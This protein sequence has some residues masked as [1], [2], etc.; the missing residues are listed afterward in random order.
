MTGCKRL[1]S[2]AF[3]QI[4]PRRHSPISVRSGTPPLRHFSF[5][6]FAPGPEKRL[7]RGPWRRSRQGGG[8]SPTQKRRPQARGAAHVQGF[9]STALITPLS[10]AGRVDR[11]RR[12]QQGWFEWQIAEGN[13]RA[14]FPVRDDGREG[15]TLS[16]EEHK[17]VIEL[18]IKTAK[19]KSGVPGDR[20][21]PAP[22]SHGRGHRFHPFTPRRWARNAVLHST[23]LLQTNRPKTA[24]YRHFQGPISEAVD[25][26]DLCL[27]TCR[28]A[29][30]STSRVRDHLA[31][32][33][34]GS[35]IVIGVKDATANCRAGHATSA[36]PAV[37]TSSRCRVRTVLF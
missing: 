8:A 33:A 4:P 35:S 1:R 23:G 27:Q 6:C 3:A 26:S 24:L 22:N 36:S 17:H 9:H 12:F 21:V 10:R 7:S 20:P 15:P 19:K 5:L 34:K 2:P 13:A 25:I 28:C 30:S 18:C 31:R 32:C 16:H 14:S 29:P 11:Q 37:R